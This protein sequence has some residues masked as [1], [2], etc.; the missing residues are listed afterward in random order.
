MAKT[1]A[2]K[3]SL[4]EAFTYRQSRAAGMSKNEIYRRRDAGEFEALGR[5]LFR[6]TGAEPAE[7]DLIEIAARTPLATLCLRSALVRHEL[8][9]AI[10]SAI[11]VA[12]P[13]GTRAPRASAVARWHHFDAA[14][15]E[16][17]RK[18]LRLTD[19]LSIGLFSAERSIIDAFRM[20]GSAGRELGVEA[21]R[22]WLRRPGSHAAELL[23]LAA[24]FPRAATPIK[25]AL[26]IL[27]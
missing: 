22:N 23:K 7:L 6:R 5:G 19:E 21:L 2:K 15:F 25:N 20:R 16:I 14:T 17:G 11:E 9:D 10:P 27:L 1:T 12:I 18:P 3:P 26:E 24:R 8:I 13:R 4:P